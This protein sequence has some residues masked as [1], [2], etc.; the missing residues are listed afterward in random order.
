[1]HGTKQM[2]RAKGDEHLA[3]VVSIRHTYG[4]YTTVVKT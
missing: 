1:M 3:V 4:V 2:V